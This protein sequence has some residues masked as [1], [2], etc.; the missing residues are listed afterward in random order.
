MK[1]GKDESLEWT[2][3]KKSLTEDLTQEEQEQLNAWLDTL[4]EHRAFYNRISKFDRTEGIGGLPEEIYRHDLNRY[5][6]KF[7][8]NKRKNNKRRLVYLTRYAAI[9]IVL[10]GVGLYFRYTNGL[11]E[12]MPDNMSAITQ[13]LPGQAAVTLRLSHGEQIVLDSILTKQTVGKDGVAIR[14]EE[15]VLRY[16]VEVNNDGKSSYNELVVPPSGEYIVVLADGTKVFLNSASRLSYPIVFTGSERRVKLTG[17]AY[18]EVARDECPFIVET[19]LEEVKVFG[20]EFNVMA[21]EDENVVQ[22]ALVKG[23]VGVQVKGSEDSGFRKIKPGELF[24]LNRETGKAEVTQ[25]DVFS[26]VAWKEGLFVSRNDDLE[27]ILRKVSRW[28][29]VEIFYQT[30]ELKHKRFFG[31]MKRQTNLQE[32]LE[33]IA[34]AGDVHFSVNNRTVTVSERK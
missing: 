9:F 19:S 17:E 3:I 5:I 25:T 8:Q 14:V 26:H 4:P 10:L 16:D 6:D 34:E 33:V 24:S 30:P 29:D 1:K 28:F 15:G 31:I 7:R 11:Q 27:T 2:L 23:S 18:F 32:V 13:V 21:Y 20:T 12:M 22:T